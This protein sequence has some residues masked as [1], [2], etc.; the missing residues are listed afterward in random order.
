MD[1]VAKAEMTVLNK[2]DY[3][4][5]HKSLKWKA[6]KG[7]WAAVFARVIQ[8]LRYHLWHC[9]TILQGVLSP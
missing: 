7:A 5:F 2:K 1:A 3:F 8:V 9:F 4:T 6:V